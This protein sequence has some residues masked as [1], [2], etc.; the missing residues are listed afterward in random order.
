MNPAARSAT[1]AAASSAFCGAA[2]MRASIAGQAAGRPRLHR[3]AAAAFQDMA[4]TPG[5]TAMR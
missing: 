4:K 2:T 1:A 3:L 5:G